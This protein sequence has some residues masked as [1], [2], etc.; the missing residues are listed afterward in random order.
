MRLPRRQ[1]LRFH[2]GRPSGRTPVPIRIRALFRGLENECSINQN[3]RAFFVMRAFGHPWRSLFLLLLVQ[4]AGVTALLFVITSVFLFLVE[5]VAI[6]PL[7]DGFGFP[8][9]LLAFTPT[10][11]VA[12]TL[13]VFG[14]QT[15]VS[16]IF[17]LHWWWRNRYIAGRMQAI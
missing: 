1:Q 16:L 2:V 13:L 14:I 8:S 6:R 4:M 15:A 11:L 9:D 17:S 10:K 12:P 7:A 5:P 3:E